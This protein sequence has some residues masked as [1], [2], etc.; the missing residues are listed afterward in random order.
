M[1]KAILLEVENNNISKY[2]ESLSPTEAT[3]YSFWKATKKIHPKTNHCSAIKQTDGKWSR[4]DVEI[5]NAFSYHLNEV[6]KP[7]PRD[8]SASIAEETDI[9]SSV[10]STFVNMQLPKLS[11][12]SKTEVEEIIN[13]LNQRKAPVYDCK[14]S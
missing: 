11:K 9:I 8:P 7:F 13:C 14:N 5:A 1:L 3:D 10:Q 4:S 12:V 6:F 2:L